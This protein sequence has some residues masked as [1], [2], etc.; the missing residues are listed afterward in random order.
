M[1]QLPQLERKLVQSMYLRLLVLRFD[2]IYDDDKKLLIRGQHS[3][4]LNS[5][6][7]V[8]SYMKGLFVDMVASV[9][10]YQFQQPVGKKSNLLE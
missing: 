1:Q 5:V 2:Q 10:L 4:R 7:D 3:S 9:G 6:E 8:R